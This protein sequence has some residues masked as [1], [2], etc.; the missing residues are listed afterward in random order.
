MFPWPDIIKLVKDIDVAVERA[1][2]YE[3][4]GYQTSVFKHYE[5]YYC[6]ERSVCLCWIMNY[7]KRA[8]NQY[9]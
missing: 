2:L 3:V 9:Q 5:A 7:T 8:D 4:C 6:N 1:F